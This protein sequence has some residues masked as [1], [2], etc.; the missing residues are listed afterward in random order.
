MCPYQKPNPNAVSNKQCEHVYHESGRV[1][2]DFN[3]RLE[4]TFE[5]TFPVSQ[6]DRCAPHPSS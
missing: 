1:D 2:L 6:A 3:F 5:H 4:N